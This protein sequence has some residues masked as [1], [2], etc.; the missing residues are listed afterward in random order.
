MTWVLSLLLLAATTAPPAPEL[1]EG[2][3]RLDQG[4]FEGALVAL[5]NAAR[6][7]GRAPERRRDLAAAHLYVGLAYLRLDQ[8]GLARDRFRRALAL[9]GRASPDERFE[10]EARA[11]FEQA[12]A[13]A[14]RERSRRKGG[15]PAAMIAGGFFAGAAGVSAG[16]TASTRGPATAKP[17]TNQAPIIATTRTPPGSPIAAVTRVTFSATAS[18]PEGN[19]LA[20]TWD[21]GDGER[22]EGPTVEHVFLRA[23]TFDV[24]LAVDDGASR[25]SQITR[26]TVR[27]MNGR[28]AVEPA[29]YRGETGFSLIQDGGLLGGNV[30]FGGL[31]QSI[32]VVF[33]RVQHPRDLQ[34]SWSDIGPALSGRCFSVFQGR[35]DETLNVAVGTAVCDSC[36]ACRPQRVYS[37]ILRRR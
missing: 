30:E 11:A 34:L 19:A 26:I 13:G 23:G 16:V 1:R 4:D 29:G 2:V 17:S 33:N 21:F 24:V 22:G 28:W 7:L 18:D 32:G 31:T 15:V 5:D 36:D 25:V 14:D 37:M 27:A 6:A 35:L 12:K 8:D 10:A 9:D 20:H 3:E